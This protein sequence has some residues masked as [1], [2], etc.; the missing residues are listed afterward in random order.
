SEEPL[1]AAAD[2]LAG[3][4]LVVLMPEGTIPRGPAFFEPELSGRWGAARLA[5]LTKVPV[6][7]IGVWGTE[8]VWPRSSRLPNVLNVTSPPLVTVRVGEPVELKYRSANADT[9]RIM[10]AISKLLPPE[11]RRRR[12]PTAE[13]LARTYPPGY[14]GDPDA[15]LDRRPG[16]D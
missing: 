13:D 15:E 2:A 10:T 3:G 7:P 5:S 14:S 9:K 16:T 6:I 11:A 1:A 8:H 4:E 12:T